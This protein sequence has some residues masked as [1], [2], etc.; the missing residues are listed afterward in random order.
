MSCH[1]KVKCPKKAKVSPPSLSRSPLL[2]LSF[3]FL[4]STSPSILYKVENGKL[5]FK[6]DLE[7]ANYDIETLETPDYEISGTV[8]LVIKKRKLN[9][10]DVE[11]TATEKETAA[12]EETETEDDADSDIEKELDI[13]LSCSSSSSL[14]TILPEA[15]EEEEPTPPALPQE[16][17]TGT[18]KKV[19]QDNTFFRSIADQIY[20]DE[21]WCLV[22][23][24][25]CYYYLQNRFPTFCFLRKFAFD[26]ENY[27]YDM[28]CDGLSK[29]YHLQIIVVNS[30]KQVIKRY[31]EESWNCI[32]IVSKK[33]GSFSSITSSKINPV[34]DV[35]TEKYD[36]GCFENYILDSFGLDV[37][38]PHSVYYP[39][40]QGK[41]VV[42]KDGT[43]A[44]VIDSIYATR[45]MLPLK[46]N[47]KKNNSSFF[48][49]KLRLANGT[50]R[51]YSIKKVTES[52]N[53]SI[54]FISR[55]GRKVMNTNFYRPPTTI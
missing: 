5:F 17:I 2:P 14:E 24:H 10:V 6:V 54:Q 13:Q 35:F 50:E 34:S 55:T 29:L 36:P 28:E 37:V 4:G 25:F 32:Y 1:K 48:Y 45:N 7:T 16:F 51:W 30:G 39:E 38:L 49:Y 26:E 27:N 22:I 53:S 31:G 18:I 33:N 15:Q 42:L 9:E 20:S 19:K 23:R 43:E 52:A 44:V 41:L 8:N 3:L 12:A 40:T 11:V 47:N 21:R 46:L